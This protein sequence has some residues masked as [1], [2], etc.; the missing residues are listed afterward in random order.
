MISR[1]TLSAVIDTNVLF[2]GLTKRGNATGLIVDAW[3]QGLFEACISDTVVYE[4]DDVLSRKLSAA[5]W[6]RVQPILKMLL[7]QAH[8]TRIS[9]T[10]RPSSPD[11]GDEHVIDCALNARAIIVTWNIKDFRLAR[12]ELGVRVAKPPQFISLLTTHLL[13]A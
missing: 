9:Y 7:S 4:Y 2:E 8:H 10:W 1:G 12:Q 6:E 3:M 11:T 13:R 5:N